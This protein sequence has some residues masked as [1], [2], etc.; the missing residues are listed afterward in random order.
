MAHALAGLVDI[1]RARS[2]IGDPYKLNARVQPCLGLL[3][4]I[5]LAI[6]G[7]CHFNGQVGGNVQVLF[8]EHPLGKPRSRYEGGIRGTYGIGVPC[9]NKARFSA[10][11]LA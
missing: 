10:E 3:P 6:A 9:K 2:W 5:P 4:H 7:G 11:H 1:Y 8:C